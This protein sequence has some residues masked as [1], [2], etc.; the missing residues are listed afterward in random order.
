VEGQL[1]GTF[2]CTVIVIVVIL[3]ALLGWLFS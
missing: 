1:M 3:M 2:L